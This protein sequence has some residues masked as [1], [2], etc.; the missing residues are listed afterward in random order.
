MELGLGKRVMS[1]DGHH[2]GHVDGFVLDSKTRDVDSL[3]VRSGVLLDHDRLVSRELIDQIA[4]DGTVTV[5]KTAA[6]MRKLP[7]FIEHEFVVAAQ[8]DLGGMPD[9]WVA[10]GTGAPPIY[11]GADSDSLGYGSSEPFYGVAPI[12]PPEVEIE[13]NL[14]EQDVVIDTGTEVFAKDGKKIGHVDELTYGPEGHLTGF[15]VRAG[16]LFHHDVTVPA[17]WIESVGE[18]HV[19]LSRTADEMRQP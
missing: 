10:S 4:P 3:I 1:S 2:I 19:R 15:I 6:E 8:Q 11:F 16:F 12:V 9:A 14:P 18:D 5:S 7:E 13:S 17:D